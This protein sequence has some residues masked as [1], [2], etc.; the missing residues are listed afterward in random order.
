MVSFM[1]FKG[2]NGKGGHIQNIKT[3]GTPKKGTYNGVFKTPFLFFSSF[4]LFLF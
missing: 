4:F 1:F 3:V 2:D